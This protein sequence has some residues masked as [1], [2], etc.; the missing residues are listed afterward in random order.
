VER[1]GQEAVAVAVREGLQPFLEGTVRVPA[2]G[3]GSTGVSLV[4]PG[5]VAFPEA[6]ESRLARRLAEQLPGSRVLTLDAHPRPM[7]LAPRSRHLGALEVRA[8]TPDEPLP[9]DTTRELPGSSSLRSALRT[10]RAPA[11]FLPADSLVARDTL[12]HLS[13]EAWG[14][15]DTTRPA[16]PPLVAER[17]GQRLLPFDFNQPEP[18]VSALVQALRA[19]GATRAP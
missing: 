2:A 3:N 10:S 14:I 15:H 12:P 11:V 6:P 19:T 5:F 9:R 7:E 4:C 13:T 18:T 1:L 17:L 16:S 8:F